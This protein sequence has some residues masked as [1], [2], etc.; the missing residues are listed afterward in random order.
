MAIEQVGP[1]AVESTELI[2]RKVALTASLVGWISQTT[3]PSITLS[4]CSKR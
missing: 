3:F 1:I 4:A 2:I